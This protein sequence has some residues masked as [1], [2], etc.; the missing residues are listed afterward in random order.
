MRTSS[1][2]CRSGVLALAVALT[3]SGA[4][5]AQQPAHAPAAHS[6]TIVGSLARSDGLPI[7]GETLHCFLWIDGQALAPL[8]MSDARIRTMNP[9]AR[10]D[11]KGRFEIRVDSAFVARHLATTTTYTLGLMRNG[12]PAPVGPKGAPVTFDLELVYRTAYRL[13]LGRIALKTP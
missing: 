7:A 4:L 8:G 9:S 2:C 10:T 5:G 3:L 11:A 6:F 12:H 13:D 1:G